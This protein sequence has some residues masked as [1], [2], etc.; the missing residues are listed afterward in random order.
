VEVNGSCV[1]LRLK[2]DAN[3]FS[4]EKNFSR[5]MFG[6]GHFGTGD[7]EIRIKSVSDFEKAK[8]FLQ[9]AYDEN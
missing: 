4:F 6:V 8:P 5:N 1:I 2:L 9:Q 7:V 3:S